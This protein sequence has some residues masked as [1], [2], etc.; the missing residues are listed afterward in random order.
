[1]HMGITFEYAHMHARTHAHSKVICCYMY[2]LNCDSPLNM[3]NTGIT[4]AAWCAISLLGEFLS[5]KT[6]AK[7][8]TD[9]VEA[10]ELAECSSSS[11][12]DIGEIHNVVHRMTINNVCDLIVLHNV[13][14]VFMHNQELDGPS[15]NCIEQKGYIHTINEVYIGKHSVNYSEHHQ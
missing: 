9:C 14:N 4:W 11:A 6:W 15:D 10:G 3:W 13:P 5:K 8:E 2:Y 1:M 12:G 7:I